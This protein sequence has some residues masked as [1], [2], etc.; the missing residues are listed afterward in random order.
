MSRSRRRTPVC[1][2]TTAQSEKQD[3]VAAHRRERRR[4]HAVLATMLAPEPACDVLP[5]RRELS[6]VWSYA[7]DGKQYLGPRPRP[8]YLR[9]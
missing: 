7:K 2:I 5:H 4:V 8:E 9:K 3:K 6:N 1:G